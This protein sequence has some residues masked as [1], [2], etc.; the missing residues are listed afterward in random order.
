VTATRAPTLA[1]ATGVV[2]FLGTG[3]GGVVAMAGAGAV[4]LAFPDGRCASRCRRSFVIAAALLQ[5][6]LRGAD[7][8]ARVT[9]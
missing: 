8:F 9:Y 5:L 2:I 4:A 3:N 6:L 7:R 1:N